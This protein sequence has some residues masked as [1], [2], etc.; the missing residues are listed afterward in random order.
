MALKNFRREMD[1]GIATYVWDMTGKSMNVI[2]VSV[3]DDFDA[4]VGEIQ[5]DGAIAAAIITSGK[6]AFSGGADLTMLQA[7]LGGF[8][9]MAVAG[10]REAAG[11]R[12]FDQ[13][14][15]PGRT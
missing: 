6:E 1:G 3:M 5:S 4:I 15:R 14:G 13:G 9:E 8:A 10:G 11:Q 2:D 12:L 7:L